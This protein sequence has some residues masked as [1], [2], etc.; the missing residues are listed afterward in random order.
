MEKEVWNSKGTRQ[1]T[2]S[3]AC[4]TE[5]VKSMSEIE[6]TRSNNLCAGRDETGHWESVVNLA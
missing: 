4:Q 5:G 3:L 6:V 1:I 2:E